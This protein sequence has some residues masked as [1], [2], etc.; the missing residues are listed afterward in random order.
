MKLTPEQIYLIAQQAGFDPQAARIMT[1]IVLAESGGDTEAWNGDVSTGDNSAGLAQINLI[2]SL[3]R[4]WT[5]EQMNDPLANLQVAF[6][7][8]GGGKNWQPWTTYTRGTYKQFTQQVDSAARNVDQSI[9]SGQD[10]VWELPE[11]KGLTGDGTRPVGNPIGNTGGGGTSYATGY[12]SS[13]PS[14][15]AGASDE[16]V[17]AYI[18]AYYG[19]AAAYLD[20]PEL[21]PLLKQAAREGWDSNRLTG[22]V[23]GTNW[24][25]TH[26]ATARQWDQLKSSDPATAGAQLESRKNDIATQASKLGINIDPSRLDQLAEMS[27]RSAWNTTQ[28]TQA[29][30]AE[31]KYNPV[32]GGDLGALTTEV[33]K[34]ASNY[35]VPV[36]DESAFG[37]AQ[38]IAAGTLTTDG[39]NQMFQ[40][41]AKG[42]FPTIADLIDKGI[43]PGQFFE[44]YKQM[45]SSE[46]EISPDQIDLVKNPQYN[47]ILDYADTGSANRR[48]MTMSEAQRYARSLPGWD[49]TSGAKKAAADLSS[50][51]GNVFGKVG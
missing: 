5:R 15:G 51:L 37:Y 45:I 46:L 44:P 27:L 6:Q 42:R 41:Q 14:L 19:Y 38:Q 17:A 32:Q 10:I 21:G 29:I 36:S 16:E 31:S 18:K 8:S 33:K 26:S 28:L 1:S 13:P 40:I 3:K 9:T 7:L 39:V 49:S 12:S 22:A 23:T 47:P 4:P 11:M 50:Y 34:A 24:W 25:K 2:P 48:V 30:A 43:T 20:D 35:F